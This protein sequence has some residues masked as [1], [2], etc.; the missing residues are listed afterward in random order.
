M[1][2]KFEMSMIRELKFFLT[3]QIH[4]SLRGIFINQAK[5]AHEILRKHGMTSCDNIGTPMSTQPL[6]A[7]LSGTP[8]DQTKYRS[9]LG[10]L[11]YLT[12]S[13]PD[14]VHA[15]CYC[16]CYQA[17]PT[18]KHLAEVKWIFRYLKNTI[19]MGLWYLKDTGFE[20]TAFSNSD[21]AGCLDIRKSTSD[22]IQ[23]L[24]GDKLV[25]W[26]SKKQ[27][28]T[29][30]S[31]AKDEYVALSACCDSQLQP[32]DLLK[33]SAKLS[34]EDRRNA[35]VTRMTSTAAKP[36]Q[37]DLYEFYLIIVFYIWDNNK[38]DEAK[39]EGSVKSCATE[40]T[41]HEM[42]V[43]SKEEFEEETEEE[44]EEEEE[45][46]LEHFDA[47]PTMKELRYHEW[48]VKNPQPPWVKAK[49]RTGNL[50][51]IKFSCMISWNQEGNRQ[52][53]RKFGILW[54]RIR[55]L[56]VFIRNFTYECDFMVLE[57]TTSVIYHDLGYIDEEEAWKFLEI[58]CFELETLSRRFFEST[59]IT[60]TKFGVAAPFQK[61][62]IHYHVLILKLQKSF[63][64]LKCNKN[65]ISQKAQVH[66]KFRNSD[67]HEL[68]HHQR[69]SKSNQELFFEEIVNQRNIR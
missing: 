25:S 22:G 24:G 39:E 43:K 21:H 63:I 17:R 3:I 69:S 30:M 10:A 18:E 57:D 4:Q 42:T 8:I 37:E 66:V 44:T 51:N 58:L 47:F 62:R 11:M 19:N 13:R 38:E 31:T 45:D 67:D 36:C 32:W 16:A 27:D 26:S 52:T 15:T 23:F 49:I 28:C 54:G 41:D 61:S 55:G 50:N 53:L 2:D 59:Y 33:Q 29:S 5:Y 40:Y 9:M 35:P 34:L 56:E 68:P 64:Q 14:I 7:D 1:H 20:L 65:V 60:G 12:S 48:L 46:N 6:D